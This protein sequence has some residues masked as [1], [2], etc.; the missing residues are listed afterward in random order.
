MTIASPGV[1][2]RTAHGLGV[3]ETISFTTTGALPTGVV[4]GTT[5]YV[6]AAGFSANSFRISATDAGSVINTTGTQSGTHT[7]Y[8]RT[9]ISAPDQRTI[10]TYYALCK[11]KQVEY[12]GFWLAGDY[13]YPS[14]R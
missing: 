12:I 10:D 8:R 4:A 9:S 1:I 13:Y 14:V 3:G 2:S 5:Y 11:N 6:I 7:L